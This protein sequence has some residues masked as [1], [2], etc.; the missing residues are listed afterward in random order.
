MDNSKSRLATAKEAATYLGISLSTLNRIEK[1]ARLLPFRTP[2]GHRRYDRAMLD[3]YLESTR[4]QPV[5]RVEVVIRH[6]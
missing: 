6:I 4:T 1:E 5:E 3:E 2:G